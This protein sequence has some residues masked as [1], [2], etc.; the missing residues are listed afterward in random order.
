MRIETSTLKVAIIHAFCT[1]CGRRVVLVCPQT[2][3]YD[4][5]GELRRH[6]PVCPD[7]AKITGDMAW[8]TYS[9]WEEVEDASH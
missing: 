1:V 9:E 8:Q 2:H 7:H 3:A 5:F 6:L 4:V